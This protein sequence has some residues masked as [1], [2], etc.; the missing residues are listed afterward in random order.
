MPQGF[1]QEVVNLDDEP[2][3]G[4]H[5]AGE[6]AITNQNTDRLPHQRL[7]LLLP[8]GAQ[9]QVREIVEVAGQ[10]RIVRRYAF[11]INQESTPQK[12]FGFHQEAGVI[13]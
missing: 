13:Q 12:S 7:G 2:Q 6:S 5:V 9:E 4:N 3:F 1:E 10:I 11:S 8:A